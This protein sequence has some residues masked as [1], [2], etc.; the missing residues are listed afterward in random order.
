MIRVTLS[1]GELDGFEIEQPAASVRL[2]VP[3]P[4][5]AE[6]VIPEW[7]RNEF[8]LGDGSRPIIRTFTPRAIGPDGLDIDIVIHDGGVASGWAEAEDPGAEV[9]I[10]G[11]GRGYEIDH[12]A[13]GMILVGDETAISAI[14]QLIEHMPESIAVEVH[15]VVADDF[16][17]VEIPDHA[18]TSITWH[19]LLPTDEMGTTMVEA[20]SAAEFDGSTAIW[21]A[22]EAA[23]MHRIRTFLFKQ[24][25]VPRSQATVRGYYKARD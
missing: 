15:L 21:C 24:I 3:E 9:A 19:K 4:N 2:L 25:G 17:Q 6:L 12:S 14:G 18:N 5:S 10:S 7:D 20:L 23:A 16:G 11:P 8:R 13:T 22:G 1:G